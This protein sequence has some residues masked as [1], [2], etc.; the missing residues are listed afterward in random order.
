VRFGATAAATQIGQSKPNK[1]IKKCA[2]FSAEIS[3]NHISGEYNGLTDRVEGAFEAMWT[4][5]AYIIPLAARRTGQCE[6]IVKLEKEYYN[7]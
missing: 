5:V 3:Y 2:T 1:K 6:R 4:K 7:D